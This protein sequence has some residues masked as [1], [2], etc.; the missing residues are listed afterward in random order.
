MKKERETAHTWERPQH[1]AATNGTRPHL[2]HH[3][4]TTTG[5]F[6]QEIC[7]RQHTMPLAWMMNDGCMILH[8]RSLP[9]ENTGS[10]WID[11]VDVRICDE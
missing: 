9:P 1:D 5:S 2:N 4:L 3:H 10:T 7:A 11:P 6:S 8:G